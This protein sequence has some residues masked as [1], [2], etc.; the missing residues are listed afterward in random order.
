VEAPLHGIQFVG[1]RSTATST[2][3]IKARQPRHYKAHN[4]HANWGCAIGGSLR[5]YTTL[6]DI[7]RSM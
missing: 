7:T 5:I 3:A 6:G 2:T 1:Q 4:H